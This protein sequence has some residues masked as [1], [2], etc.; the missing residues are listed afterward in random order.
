[1]LVTE[2]AERALVLQLLALEGV[3]QSTADTL[4]PHRLTT[5]LFELASAFTTFFDQCPVLRADTAEQRASRLVLTD[6]TGRTLRTGLGLLGIEAPE[7]M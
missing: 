5:Y 7:R 4:Q 2:P 3:V 6:L 1:V